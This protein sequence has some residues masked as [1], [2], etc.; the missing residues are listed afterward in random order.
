MP[1]K[2]IPRIA[3]LRSVLRLKE[4]GEDSKNGE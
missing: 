4:A 1:F 3:D 2:V